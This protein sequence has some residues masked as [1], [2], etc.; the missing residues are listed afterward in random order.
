MLERYRSALPRSEFAALE[1]WISTL[2]PFQRSWLFEQAD[3]ALCLKSRQIGMSHTTSGLGVLWGAF[4][5]ELTTIISIGERESNEVLDKA[6]RHAGVLA[7]LGSLMARPKSR[8]KTEIVFSSGGR[9]MALPSSGGRSFS[10]NV[11]LDEYAY[12]EQAAAV[13]DAAAAVTLLG[14]K[15]RVASTPNGIGNEFHKTWTHAVAADSGWAVHDV[16][17]DLAIAQG[18]P[19]DIKKCWSLAKGDPRLFDQLFRC[20][21]LD[22]EQQYIPTA[23][24]EACSTDD[25]NPHSAHGGVTNAGLDIGKTSDRTELVITRTDHAGTRWVVHAEGCKR[26]NWDDLERLAALA[27]SPRFGCRRLCVDATGMGEFPAEQLQKRYGG[28]RVEPVKFTQQSKEDLATRL[29][30]AFTEETIR[31]PR[32]DALLRDDLCSIRRLVTAA[33]N[34]RYDAPQ[35]DEGHGDRAWALALALHAG[36]NGPN[37][38]HVAGGR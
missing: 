37:D 19:V 29:Y 8:S 7:G 13:W 32:S 20:K 25:C 17:I 12:Q 14:C 11:F 34:I 24:V 27:F 9:V 26:T 22:N 33:G 30:S 15:L 18:Y 5:G 21:F 31:I 4:H 3:Q 2:Y 23:A 35:T 10:G 38:K 28:W 16:P 36:G 6:A 1:A